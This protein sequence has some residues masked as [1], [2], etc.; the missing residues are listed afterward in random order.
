MAH[1]K[2]GRLAEAEQCYRRILQQQPD[3]SESLCL[4]GMIGYQAGRIEPALGL[5]RRAAELNPNHAPY[6]LNVGNCCQALGRYE[7][8]V[9]AYRRAIAL[10]PREAIAYCNLGVALRS[11]GDYAGA[12]S[13]YQQALAIQPQNVDTKY[14]LAN[15]Y[16]LLGDFNLASSLYHETLRLNPGYVKARSNL[17]YMN[18]YNVLCTPE[19]MLSL[20][21]EW[22]RVHGAAGRAAQYGHQ[23]DVAA[24]D[25]RLRIGYVSPDFRQHSVSYF[26]EPILAA[27]DRDQV[28]VICYAEVIPPGDEVTARL[29][30]LADGWVTT[31]GLG[32]AALAQR[33]HDDRIDILIDLAGHTGNNRLGAFTYKPAPVQ[34]TYLGYFTTTGLAAMDYWLTDEVMC[35]VDTIE[36]SVEENYRLPRCCVCYQPPDDAPAVV[37]RPGGQGV[38]F[39]SFN[40]LS[41]VAPVAIERWAEIM[42]QVPESRL[43]MK[44]WQLADA[45]ACRGLSEQ[46]SRRGIEPG[47]LTLRAHTINKREHLAMYGEVDIALDSMPRTGGT[48][49]AEALYMGVPV[50]SLAGQRF[51]ERLSASMLQ[52]VGLGELVADS[53][54][55]Y[56]SL[57]V[58]LAGDEARRR[59]LRAGLREQLLSSPLCDAEDLTRTLELTYRQLWRRWC[60][61]G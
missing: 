29:Q 19:E 14:N 2:A 21:R 9:T 45:G 20:H 49:T 11:M 39:G 17:L 59:S 34:V 44:A 61:G 37:D 36:L 41:K 7:E 55:D 5:F 15:C 6:H 12:V 31:V 3:H 53:G 58:R 28:E 26:F 42:R 4:L 33:I 22:D 32:D 27:H 43:I 46:F 52:A 13:S 16:R 54:E 48:T 35:P 38:V 51:I 60:E 25:R 24:S 23:R 57:A 1:H 10:N 47:R 18:S 8:A 56:I 50:I 30:A 40:D